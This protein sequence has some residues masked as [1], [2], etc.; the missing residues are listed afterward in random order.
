MVRDVRV[1]LQAELEVPRE[2]VFPLIASA[3]GLAHWLDAAELE[4]RLGG[5]VRLRLR[6]AVVEGRVLALDPPQHISFSWDYPDQPLGYPTVVAFDAI[7]HGARTHVTLRHVG[8]RSASQRDLHD[9]LWR[10]WFGRFR[11]AAHAA[12]REVAAVP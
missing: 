8:F 5:A 12:E 6:E 3:E 4:A 1:E 2:R 9:A 7:D 10:H 11:E